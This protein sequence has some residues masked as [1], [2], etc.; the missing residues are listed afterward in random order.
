MFI[1]CPPCRKHYKYSAFFENDFEERHLLIA[2]GFIVQQTAKGLKSHDES[3]EEPHESCQWNANHNIDTVPTEDI[4]NETESDL[5]PESDVNLNDKGPDIREMTTCYD[6]AASSHGISERYEENQQSLCQEP[7]L[8]F[9]YGEE[10]KIARWPIP[11]MAAQGAIDEYFCS[12]IVPPQC[13]FITG[14]T[15]IAKLEESIQP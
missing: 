9:R 1:K 11:A 3:S 12:F 6:G 2:P 7:L 13:S 15:F 10:F 5:E 14:R 4:G 8:L